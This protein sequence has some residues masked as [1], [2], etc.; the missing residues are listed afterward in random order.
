L[1]PRRA[2]L[3]TAIFV[4]PRCL[5]AAISASNGASALMPVFS[6]VCLS[7]SSTRVRVNTAEIGAPLKII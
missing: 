4:R 7:K 6:L 3:P 5:S 1:P 2:A